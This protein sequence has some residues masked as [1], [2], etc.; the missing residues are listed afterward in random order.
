MKL[1]YQGQVLHAEE[2]LILFLSEEECPV[3]LLFNL[4]NRSQIDMTQNSTR[5]QHS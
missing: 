5:I 4:M 3:L 1:I 2:L